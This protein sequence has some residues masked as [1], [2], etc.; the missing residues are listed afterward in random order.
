MLI[1]SQ[2]RF[3]IRLL[4][5]TSLL[6]FY[7]SAIFANDMENE[8]KSSKQILRL[9]WENDVFL[10]TDREYTNGIRMEYGVYKKWYTPSSFALNG[11][12]SI[13]PYLANPSY[14][15]SGISGLQTLQT[16][17][18][19]SRSDIVYGERPYSSLGLAASSST[20]WWSK[21]SLGLEFDL[22][23]IGSDVQGKSIQTII[24]KLIQ[25]P[26]PQG[27]NSQIPNR[28]GFQINM[29]HKY[30]W[31]K[32]IGWQTGVKLGT[33]DTSLTIGPVFRW[34]KIS[35]PVSHGTLLNDSSPIYPTEESEMYFWIRP[36]VKYQSLNTTLQGTG[37]GLPDSSNLN[38]LSNLVSQTQPNSLIGSPLYSQVNEDRDAN[39]MT[40][41]LV[42]EEL[43][44]QETS[45]GLNYLIF[46]SVFNGGAPI[47]SGAKSLILYDISNH[48]LNRAD[49]Q[50]LDYFIL[51]TLS[52]S[53]TKTQ[54]IFSKYIAYQYLFRNEPDNKNSLALASALLINE[55]DGNQRYGVEL[56]HLQGKIATGFLYNNSDWYFQIA[57]EVSTLE[58]KAANSVLPYHRYASLQ[59]G[60]KF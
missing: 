7:V 54:N 29:D 14:H 22:G 47:D 52:R 50:F 44:H 38:E 49:Y 1:S 58:Y 40:R 42:Y 55:K 53:E 57:A 37:K 28:N 46:N 18:N 10:L 26:I 2:N 4:F 25:A 21:S 23:K 56:K 45:K 11:L 12:T 30:F 3:I 24:H 6:L 27:W 17:T 13:I 39:S 32:E 9:T 60:K 8:K 41:F 34:G 19:L 16:P 15:Y 43:L 31:K 5:I 51:D 35:S 48:N 20:V 36:Q 59:M 33:F